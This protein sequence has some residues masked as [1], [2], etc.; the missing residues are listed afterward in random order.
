LEKNHQS[1]WKNGEK[2]YCS[3]LE[4]EI[5]L[6]DSTKKK[7]RESEPIELLKKIF[8]YGNEAIYH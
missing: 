2:K 1:N 6:N 3:D 8:L 7:I 4:D 5:L